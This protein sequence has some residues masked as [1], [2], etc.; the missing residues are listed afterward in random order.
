M[1]NM[2]KIYLGIIA[3]LSLFAIFMIVN[4]NKL[5]DV[6]QA[7]SDLIEKQQAELR[8]THLKWLQCQYG[9]DAVSDL[10]AN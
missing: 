9:E 6:S 3:L 10:L 7:Q 8:R 5:L 1:P 2:N 4:V